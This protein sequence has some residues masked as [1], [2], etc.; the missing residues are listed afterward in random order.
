MKEL[1]HNT[2]CQSPDHYFVKHEEVAEKLIF[3][4]IDIF[5]KV[6]CCLFGSLS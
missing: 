1:S 4:H 5:T 3:S 2:L 6:L